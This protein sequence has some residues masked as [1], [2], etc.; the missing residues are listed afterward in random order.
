MFQTGSGSLK[1]ELVEGWE[2]IPV[3]WSHPDVAAMSTDSQGRAYVFARSEHPVMVYERDGR[4]LGSWGEGV[5]P[6]PHGIFADKDDFLYL[7]D[8][9]DHTVRKCTLEGKQ[10]MTLGTPGVPSETGYTGDTNSVVHAAGPFHRPTNI[11]TS[12]NG[13][14]YAADGYGNARVHRFSGAGQL[15]QSW[16]EPG[17]A[18]GQFRLPHGIWVH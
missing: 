10:L 2:Q 6:H 13:S 8:D 12:P 18:D 1:Y 16:G 7:V 9:G 3:G 4:F 14:L 15:L 17:T 5:F 11:V